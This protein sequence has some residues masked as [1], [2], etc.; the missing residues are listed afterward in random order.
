ENDAEGIA[1][2]LRGMVNS[3]FS[4]TSGSVKSL[5][6]LGID[7]NGN[8]NSIAIADQSKLDAALSENLTSVKQ[9]F[10]DTSNGL[11]VQLNSYL[12]ETAGTDGT[13]ITK[14]S[15]LAK[16]AGDI[17]T[18]VADLE[19]IVQ[20]DRQRLIDDFIAMETAQAKSNQQLRFLQQRFGTMA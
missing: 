7:S 5:S 17:D 19:R 4:G 14:Q 11:A 20:A 10:A 1:Q 18:Q 2:K 16:S 8:D 12:D 3:V 15:N 13:L 9:L 6:D